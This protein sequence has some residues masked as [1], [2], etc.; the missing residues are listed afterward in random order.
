[1]HVR[2]V[3]YG[4]NTLFVLACIAECGPSG[5]R[6]LAVRRALAAVNGKPWR[7]G[8]YCWYFNSSHQWFRARGLSLGADRGLWKRQ[9]VNGK[10]RWF[11][12]P[13]G[14]ARLG[15]SRATVHSGG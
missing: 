12:T 5:A 4:S 11:L 2:Y 8:L 6:S 10:A 13:R 7:P 1:M 15:Q 9:S 3:A 14:L